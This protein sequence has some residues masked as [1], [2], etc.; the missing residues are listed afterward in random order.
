MPARLEHPLLG[1][2]QGQQQRA[3]AGPGRAAR[4]GRRAG[5]RGGRP[6]AGGTGSAAVRFHC[7]AS[8]TLE[9]CIALS[10]VN[11][12]RRDAAVREGRGHAVR[13]RLAAVHRPEREASR[14]WLTT[15][16]RAGVL[17]A[18]VL[19]L[20]PQDVAEAAAVGAGAV[21]AAGDAERERTG[22]VALVGQREDARDLVA[23]L[24][25]VGVQDR[26][27]GTAGGERDGADGREAAELGVMRERGGDRGPD[28]EQHG[29]RRD[30]GGGAAHQ[31]VP[32][33]ATSWPPSRQSLPSIANAISSAGSA[34]RRKRACGGAEQDEGPAEVGDREA[35]ARLRRPG[36]A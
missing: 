19:D 25:A 1:H 15:D 27:A 30:D 11:G 23:G 3:R 34:S 18:Q 10:P 17:A 35:V 5:R 7:S 12:R 16:S 9:P 8:S 32:R 33:S 26:D 24:E 29:D 21:A 20:Q 28:R 36:R 13:A 2:A 6:V 4:L 22:L 14:R 31:D